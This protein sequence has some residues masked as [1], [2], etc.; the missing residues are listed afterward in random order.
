MSANETWFVDKNLIPC[1]RTMGAV[2]KNPTIVREALEKRHYLIAGIVSGT[3]TN[4]FENCELLDPSS[5]WLLS[6]IASS[7]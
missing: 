4:I 6:Q 7:D 2:R 3:L 1:W 5:Q